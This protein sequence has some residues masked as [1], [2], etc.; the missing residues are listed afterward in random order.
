M[1]QLEEKQFEIRLPGYL[2][3]T[4]AIIGVENWNKFRISNH[5][6]NFLKYLKH[7]NKSSDTIRKKHVF[8]SRI[9]L[10]IFYFNIPS[11]TRPFKNLNKSTAY[12]TGL[13]RKAT[14]QTNTM[15]TTTTMKSDK[16]NNIKDKGNEE[17]TAKTMK[18]TTTTIK[19]R[20]KKATAKTTTKT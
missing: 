8:R 15:T 3:P 20:T 7:R 18:I 9:S 17:G 4:G 16:N 6:N 2:L 5:S 10:K 12:K 19:A 13:F 1:I 11:S 14:K